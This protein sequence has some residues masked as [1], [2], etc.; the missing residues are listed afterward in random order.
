MASKW[1]VA[2]W[3]NI[4]SGL[5]LVLPNVRVWRA[6]V[7]NWHSISA[8]GVPDEVSDRQEPPLHRQLYNDPAC[9]TAVLSR[10]HSPCMFA[11]SS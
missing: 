7:G 6:A 2:L 1:K 9:Q 4:C 11:V 5:Q 3:V 10:S 8:I